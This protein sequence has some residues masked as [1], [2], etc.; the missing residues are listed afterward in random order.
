MP[1]SGPTPSRQRNSFNVADLGKSSVSV[2]STRAT[3]SECRRTA[4]SP[5]LFAEEFAFIDHLMAEYASPVDSGS[6]PDPMNTRYEQPR[7][8]PAIPTVPK[9]GSLDSMKPRSSIST[10]A[11][12]EFKPLS[13][14]FRRL[15]L[16][17]QNANQPVYGTQS[18]QES[19]DW[20]CQTSR[21]IEAGRISMDSICMYK[22]DR[23]PRYIWEAMRS[24][25]ETCLPGPRRVQSLGPGWG[26]SDYS[27]PASRH[28]EG[29]LQLVRTNAAR[30][31]GKAGG[32]QAR[33][34][35]ESRRHDCV[36]AALPVDLNKSLPALPL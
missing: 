13:R 5:T 31:I 3:D 23:K 15:R 7:A 18:G 14:N 6:D 4:S 19:P 1:T 29:A 22:R 26:D 8:S 27:A 12:T 33:I 36:Q 9:R 16:D 24:P 11:L 34:R 28:S 25:T 20:A 17:I 2:L 32:M 21:A 35:R 10:G 30:R